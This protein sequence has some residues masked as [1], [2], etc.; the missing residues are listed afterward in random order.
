MVTTN[1]LVNLLTSLK[2]NYTAQNKY[3]ICNFNKFC[4]EVLLI[5]YKDGLISSYQVDTE[6]NKVKI[7]LKY[8]K[9]RPLIQ[10]LKLLSKPSL[11]LFLD[12]KTAKQLLRKYDYFLISSS[13]G[14]ISSKQIFNNLTETN[15]KI[16]GQ[17][18]GTH[19]HPCCR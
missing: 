12:Y 16:G 17:V 7:E 5:L 6:K 15:Y 2:T 9:D 3:A 14:I 19:Y 1:I 18:F 10:E 13:S 11:K 8:L 4:L